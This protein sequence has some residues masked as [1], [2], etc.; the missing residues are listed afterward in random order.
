MLYLHAKG[1]AGR[2]KSNK[3][4]NFAPTAPDEAELRRL[5]SHYVSGLSG[6]RWMTDDVEIGVSPLCQEP[7][8]RGKTL[9]VKIY[10]GEESGDSRGGR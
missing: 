5:L 8:D 2:K 4:I 9:Q 10:R 6:G 1:K 7:T 3:L